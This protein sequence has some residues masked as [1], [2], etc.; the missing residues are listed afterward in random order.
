MSSTPP[1]KA[2]HSR[3]GHNQIG[4]CARLCYLFTDGQKMKSWNNPIRVPDQST[5][6]VVIRDIKDVFTGP[7]NLKTWILNGWPGA[8][9]SRAWQAKGGPR[10]VEAL[11][12]VSQHFERP[13]IS[14]HAVTE[15]GL[16]WLPTCLMTAG[17]CSW[18]SPILRVPAWAGFG[19]AKPA[20]YSPRA[21]ATLDLLRPLYTDCL[22]SS[23]LQALSFKKNHKVCIQ[24]PMWIVLFIFI[25][26]QNES[27]L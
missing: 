25:S 18:Q 13:P 3:V 24:N 14:H 12:V 22:I 9:S 20:P 10:L 11:F 26:A 7:T 16:S 5:G 1:N 27:N 2:E 17:C 23:W 4:M 21:S 8:I 19:S 15:T 6:C